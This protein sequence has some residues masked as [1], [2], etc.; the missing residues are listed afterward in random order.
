[1]KLLWMSGSIGLISPKTD[2]TMKIAYFDYLK[3]GCLNLELFCSK[4]LIAEI[5]QEKYG[6][7]GLCF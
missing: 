5:F 4:I 3:L 7:R 2:L 1:M 6:A